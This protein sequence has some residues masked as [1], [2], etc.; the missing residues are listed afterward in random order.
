MAGVGGNIVAESSL[1]ELQQ[2]AREV[3]GRELNAAKAG[4]VRGRLPTMA[5]AVRILEQAQAGLGEIVP[6]T[7]HRVPEP[8]EKRRGGR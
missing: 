3:F 7:V 6:A 4:A 8:K 1:S 2:L 5:R